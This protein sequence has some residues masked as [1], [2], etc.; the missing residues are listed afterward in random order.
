MK[1]E[2]RVRQNHL[3]EEGRKKVADTDTTIYKKQDI[4]KWK[5]LDKE[6]IDLKREEGNN[7]VEELKDRKRERAIYRELIKVSGRKSITVLKNNGQ[8][9]DSAD[10]T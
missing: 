5:M 2:E 6:L 3:E 7:G 4:K 10:S 1:S 8:R 9:K